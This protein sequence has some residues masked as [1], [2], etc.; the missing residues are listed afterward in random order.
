MRYEITDHGVTAYERDRPILTMT[1]AQWEVYSARVIDATL[2]LPLHRPD[3]TLV[4]LTDEQRLEIARD[5]LNLGREI[6]AS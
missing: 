5:I 3:G 1:R 2:R 6:A 4:R